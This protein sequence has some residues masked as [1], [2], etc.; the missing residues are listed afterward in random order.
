MNLKVV[1]K[2]NNCPDCFVCGTKNNFGLNTRFY[3]LENNILV[4]ITSGK[5][6]HN[7][8]PG[9]MHGGIISALIDETIGRAIQIKNKDIFG[10][11]VELNIRY[12][13]PTPLNEKIYIFGKIKE[14]NRFTFSG[15]GYLLDSNG[16]ILAKGNA[17][18]FKLPPEKISEEYDWYKVENELDPEEI[19]IPDDVYEKIMKGE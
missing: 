11:T 6:E 16:E 1:G 12:L 5:D 2:Q 15:I 14:E 8:Y 7:S 10:V 13:K 18:Y 17:K 9:R 4:A 19:E 3:E